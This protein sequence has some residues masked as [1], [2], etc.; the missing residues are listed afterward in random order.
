MA[1]RGGDNTAACAKDD[2]TVAMYRKCLPSATCSEF[3]DCMTDTAEA[4]QPAIASDKPRAEQCAQHVEQGMRGIANSIMML[5]EIQP[6]SNDKQRDAQ[7]CLFDESRPW[8]ECLTPAEVTE[9]NRY[10]TQRQQDCE[11]WEPALAACILR[12]PGATGCNEDE[13]PMW[14]L[15][16]ERGA[17]GPAVAWTGTLADHDAYD[18][19]DVQLAWIANKSL[20]VRDDTG[21]RALRDGKPLWHVPLADTVTGD[22]AF[23]G[24]WIVVRDEGSAQALRVLD[25]TTGRQYGRA[26][27][28]VA[29]ERHGAAGDKILVQLDDDQLFELDPAKCK[30][31]K[32]GKACATR[33]GQL[34]TDDS[35]YTNH[36]TNVGGLVVMMSSEGIHVADRKAA[37]VHA[38]PFDG[39]ETIVPTE[40]GAAVIHDS[41]IELLSFAGCGRGDDCATA[42]HKVSWVS[43]IDPTAL[44]GGGIAFNDHGIEEK[45]VV[46]ERDGSTWAVKTNARGR[47]AGD[48]EHIYT[49]S[50]GR[51]AK[52]PTRL[53]ALSR[54][55][56][57]AV[58]STE[59]LGAAFD[60]METLVVVRDGMLAARVD[61]QLYAINLATKT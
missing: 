48:G 26:L 16:V 20:I 21:L 61:G 10:A 8:R 27:V 34:N 38:L 55:T 22:V 19:V 47:V 11:T 24:K 29:L 45:T 15:P 52:E 31:D 17:A 4:T 35:V 50:F 42:T 60:A 57:K 14:E 51:S 44:P 59:L 41:H 33:L 1:M 58:W 54:K 39:A 25:A 23:A 40:D 37:T 32:P 18:E 12:Q 13:Y 7:N 30:G 43:S 6:R 9:A 28:D 53:L 2:K 3:M 56:G 46:V 49:V 5:G 36:I